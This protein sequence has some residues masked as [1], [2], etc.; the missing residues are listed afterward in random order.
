M[1]EPSRRTDAKTTPKP[2]GQG[3]LVVLL[4]AM[5]MVNVSVL[6]VVL[7]GDW[8]E[9]RGPAGDD[10]VAQADRVLSDDPASPAPAEPVRPG[11]DSTSRPAVGDTATP[12]EHE[13]AE[14]EPPADTLS[15]D[16]AQ[17][18]ALAEPAPGDTIA[19]A[20]PDRQPPPNVPDEA[21]PVTAPAPLEFFGIPVLE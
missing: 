11:L 5:L 16:P 6:I 17:A 13:P 14:P 19:D 8:F 2:P 9:R 4:S 15:P 18:D 10:R 12:L 3:A 20:P 21:A 7:A 1:P